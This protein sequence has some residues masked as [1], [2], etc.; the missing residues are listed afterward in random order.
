MAPLSPEERIFPLGP[1]AFRTRWDELQRE[2]EVPLELQQ[3]PGT[4]RGG[5]AVAQF[6][7]D[8]DIPLLLWRMRLQSTK[9]L[10]HY[11]QEVT[12]RTNLTR[13]TDHARAQVA[14]YSTQY[15]NLLKLAVVRLRNGDWSPLK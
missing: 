13:L 1:G 7:I 2:L 6:N 5:G 9:T 14:Q 8:E 15:S 3:T 10:E 4:M 12:A 11:L